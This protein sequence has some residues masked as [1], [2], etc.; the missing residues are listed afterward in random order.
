MTDLP[1][2]PS[3]HKNL[4]SRLLGMITLGGSIGTGI[5]LASGSVLS[6]AGPG[7]TLLAYLLMGIMIYFLMTIL[8]EM[9]AFMPSSGSFYQ[10]AS[11]FVD[12]SLG[13]AL[14][15]N[16]WYSWAITIAAEIAAS[17]LLIQFWFPESLGWLWSGIFLLFI[18]GFNAISTKVFGEIEYWLSVIK[19]SVIGL[20]IITGF[21]IISGF[22]ST[23]SIG[24]TNWQI[25]DA[26]FH[27]GWL[28]VISAIMLAGFSFQGTELLG[29]AA[30][31]SKSPQESIPKV[32]K[33]V[34]WRIFI[35]FIL[36]LLIITFM[37]PYTTAANMDHNITLSPFTQAFTVFNH[38]HAAFLM[39]AVILVAILSTANSG[40]YVASRMLWFLAKEKHLP[41]LFARVN[42]KGIPVYALLATSSISCL[43]FLTYFLGHNSIYFWL[44][45]A[46]GLSGFIAWTGIA[47]SHYRFRKAYLHQG[48]DLAQLPYLAKG[49]PYVPLIIFAVC[50]F[51]IAS[52]NIIAFLNHDMDWKELLISYIGLP[53]FLMV[54]LVNKK[55]SNSKM[56]HLSQCNFNS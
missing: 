24:F 45:N 1:T 28:G 52:H 9:A 6:K 27:N 5:F 34:F 13:Y 48:K 47:I 40:M 50:L 14:G 29:I 42:K 37:V 49:Y 53:L 46:G 20:F 35:F 11:Q 22:T 4:D 51:I 8:G 10:Y 43:A 15:W 25:G 7:G 2:A 39:N 16:Y 44:V 56:V 19:I 17:S 18:T 55:I 12:P 32:I 54:W 21:A 23:P 33:L 26:P 30:G 41:P 31:E 3:L 38:S 36:S